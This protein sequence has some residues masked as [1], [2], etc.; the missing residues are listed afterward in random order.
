MFLMRSCFLVINKMVFRLFGGL[1][2]GV[3]CI[4]G[5]ITVFLR[6]CLLL[7]QCLVDV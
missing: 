5:F 6:F 1:T 4:S 7:T 3:G 2:P